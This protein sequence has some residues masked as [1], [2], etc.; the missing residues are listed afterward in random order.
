MRNAPI[1]SREALI[2]AILAYDKIGKS[3][4]SVLAIFTA[5]LSGLGF[6]EGFD[7]PTPSTYL[8]GLA[9]GFA[10][11]AI[12]RGFW[13]GAWLLPEFIHRNLFGVFFLTAFLGFASFGVVSYIGNQK[14]VAG[15]VSLNLADDDRANEL[16]NTGREI[17][18]WLG[19]LGPVAAEVQEREDQ[20]IRTAVAEANG[21]GPSG[22]GGKGPVYHSFIASGGKYGSAH[23]IL[24][25]GVAQANKIASAITAKLAE[26]RAI[27]ADSKLGRGER[28][29]KLKTTEAD[30]LALMRKALAV[31]PPGLIEAAAQTIAGGVQTPSNARGASIAR[32]AEISADMA[33]YAQILMAKAKRIAADE[34]ELPKQKSQSQ[35]EHLLANALRMPGLSLAAALFD[36]CG[37]III[38]FRYAAYK[39]LRARDDEEDANKYDIYVTPRDFQRVLEMSEQAKEARNQLLEPPKPKGK[40][41]GRPRGSKNRKSG[42]D[43]S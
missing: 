17:V 25:G 22:K 14:V 12:A 3:S 37:W 30:I 33:G 6:V 27:R 5:T 4:L 21:G 7:D 10:V 11:Y 16:G 1:F 28:R 32:I 43:D 36:A 13:E 20:A 38:F 9:F 42:G 15:G 31:N 35:E 18:G 26:M 2:F 39:S 19:A 34:P 41:R 24:T 29:A 23:D 8:I 40:P